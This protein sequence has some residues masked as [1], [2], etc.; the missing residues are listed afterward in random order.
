[1][2]DARLLVE[3]ID[4]GRGGANP[5][6]GSGLRGL[7]DRV[8]ALDGYLQLDSPVGTGTRLAV[9]IPLGGQPDQ[10]ISRP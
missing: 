4:D 5:D 2:Q 10:Q 1:V 3:L 7:A 8:E 6:E 9:E